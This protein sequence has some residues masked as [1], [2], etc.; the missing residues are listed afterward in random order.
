[1]VSPGRAAG[2]TGP[3]PWGRLGK[4]QNG[5]TTGQEVFDRAMRLLGYTDIYEQADSL[6]Y[7]DLY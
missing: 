7:A 5:M 2:H 6:Q 3:L 1:M 4:E